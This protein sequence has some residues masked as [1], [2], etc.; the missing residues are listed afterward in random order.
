M[1]LL[2]LHQYDQVQNNSIKK[3]H[4]F[5][6]GIKINKF[7]SS[8]EHIFSKWL[9]KRFNLWNKQFV[10][11]NGTSIPYQKLIIPC[12]RT[13]NGDLSKIENLINKSL[14]AGFNQF[15]K[16]PE[17]VIFL[18]LQKI[19]YEVL[20]AEGRLSFDQKNKDIGTIVD[21]EFIEGHKACHLFLQ[22]ARNKVKFHKPYPW[23]IFIFE[24]QKYDTKEFNFDYR[25]HPSMVIAIRMGS[26]G[27]IACLQDNNTQKDLFND[28]FKKIQ[29]IQLHP[30]QFNEL[31]AKIFYSESLRN[32]NPKYIIYEGKKYL[33]IQPLPLFDL[34]SKPI[35]DDWANAEYA[36]FLSFHCRCAY[37]KVYEETTD[38]CRTFLYDKENNLRKLDIKNDNLRPVYNGK[39]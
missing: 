17:K 7:N 2:S 12:C 4:C 31:I 32:R 30:I 21:N 38:R 23:S 20:Y 29:K 16:L 26:I 39:K 27:I 36:K 25:D 22:A 5:L 19:Y 13:C 15:K 18:W 28:V 6:C 35:Y 11:L 34:S 33:E 9:L 24:L 3:D 8:K 10:L 1:S 37:D 14:S